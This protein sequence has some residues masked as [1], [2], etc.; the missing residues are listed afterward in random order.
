MPTRSRPDRSAALVVRAA[1][2]GGLPAAPRSRRTRGLCR[3]RSWGLLACG[4][5]Q[6]ERGNERHDRRGAHEQERVGKWGGAESVEWVYGVRTRLVP[7]GQ[8][9]GCDRRSEAASEEEDHLIYTKPD[10]ALLWRERRGGRVGVGRVDRRETEA[11]SQEARANQER[12]GPGGEGRDRKRGYQHDDKARPD[13]RPRS[14]QVREP[15]RERRDHRDDHGSRRQNEPDARRRKAVCFREKERRQHQAPDVGEHHEEPD[16]RR[17]EE[18]PVSEE[19]RRDEGQARG[20]RPPHEED[21]EQGRKDEAA[22]RDGGLEAADLP[23][24]DAEQRR[25]GT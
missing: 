2:S 7:E 16:C 17:R 4:A 25:P 5:P 8:E 23:L 10:P 6:A 3:N 13:E 21:R 15:A 22:P 24:G 11:Q 18:R 9:R 12:R 1:Q 20:P 19:F 14:D